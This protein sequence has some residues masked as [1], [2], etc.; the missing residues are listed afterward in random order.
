MS[1]CINGQP[2]K[3]TTSKVLKK[4]VSVSKSVGNLTCGK[5]VVSD[6]SIIVAPGFKLAGLFDVL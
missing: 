4:D 5:V 6:E 2:R 3:Y 1:I